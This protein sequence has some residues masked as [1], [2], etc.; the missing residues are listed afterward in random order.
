MAEDR[1]RR[2]LVERFPALRLL[3]F[4]GGRRRIPYVQQTAA[5][6]CGSACLAMVLGLHGRTAGLDEVREVVGYGRGG[7]DALRI[8]EA[9]RRFGL[10]GRG[11]RVESVDDLR[12]VPR[13]AI[14]HWRFSHYVVLDR[15]TRDTVHVVDPAAGR[16]RL[17]M[18]EASRA[19]TGIALAFE[20]SERFEPGGSDRGSSQLWHYLGRILSHSGLLTRVVVTSV[21]VQ[22]FALS[23]PFL[24]GILVDRVIPRGDEHLL[25]VLGVGLAAIVGFHFLSSLVRSH[26]LLHLRTQLDAR[27]SLDFL[28]HLVDLPYGFFQK[29]SAGDLMMRLNSNSTI[30]EILTSGALSAV[31]D[32]LLVFLYLV[33]L[34][35]ASARMAALVL[36]LGAIRVVVFMVVRRKHRD[37][38]SQ[39]LHRQARSQGYQVQM[40]S[41]IETLKATGAEHRAVEHWSNLFVDVLNVSLSRG[42][43][44]AWVES[45]LSALAIGSPLAVLLYGGNL[46]LAGELSL[47]VMLAVNALAT[48]FLQPLST[49]VGTAF[50]LQRMGSYLD[51]IEDVLDTPKEQEGRTTQPAPRLRGRIGLEGVSFRYGAGSPYVV[52]EVSVDIEPGS[53]VALV[54]RSGAGK[55]T[56]AG[57]LVGLYEPQEGTITFDGFSLAELELRSVRSQLGIVPQHPYLF[58]DTVRGNITL[59]DPTLRLGQVIEAARLAQIHDEILAMPL[60]YETLMADGGASLSG[61][62]RQRIALARALVGK[63]AILLLDEATS[64]LDAITEAAIHRELEALHATRIVISHRLSTVR[65]A[66]QILVME[67]GRLAERGTHD[68]LMRHGGLYRALIDEQLEKDEPAAEAGVG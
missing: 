37:L 53:F 40:L 56:L 30:R 51:R 18:R 29:R 3:G 52:R 50:D 57:L 4:S 28:D 27:L 25:T 20:P 58:G 60:G 8:L 64:H 35:G 2:E 36:V 44:D 43:L 65:R 67:G 63:P 39:S 38:M 23:V 33:L 46:V 61:G 54:G 45:L 17:P 11:V 13:G 68:E 7:A 1:A 42:R 47:G 26:L 14:L 21:L 24:I 10:R 15:V 5:S 62:Q 34:F 49:L 12:L 19:F 9:G 22:L 32:G 66:D 6:D 55:S 31:L 41:G 59:S 48:G 16:Q